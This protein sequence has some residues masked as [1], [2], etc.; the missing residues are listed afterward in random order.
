MGAEEEIKKHLQCLM[1]EFFSS[2]KTNGVLLDF[3]SNVYVVNMVRFIASPV[4]EQIDKESTVQKRKHEHQINWDR[5]I[6]DVKRKTVLLFLRS[7]EKIKSI[8]GSIQESFRVNT[9][10]VR[11]ERK[12]L[13]DKRKKGARKK[14]FIQYKPI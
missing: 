7:L 6:G 10:A 8:I 1:V 13:R 11:K 5:V 14:A 9:E 2:L 12:S 4:H 3:Y